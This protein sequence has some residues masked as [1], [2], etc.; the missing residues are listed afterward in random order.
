MRELI[1]FAM[2]ACSTEPPAPSPAQWSTVLD[3]QDR[4]LLSVWGSGNDVFAVGGG[5]GNG[6]PTLAM[7][8]DGSAW[9]ELSPGGADTFWWVNG[10]SP[11]DVWMVGTG[12]RIAHWDGTSF[13]PHTSGTSETLWGVWAFSP[14]DAWAV[15]KVVLHFDGAAW[16]KAPVLVDRNLF[17]VWGTSSSDLYAVGEG[18][19][20]LH[21]AGSTWKTEPSSTTGTLFTVFGCSAKEVY[22]VGG[23]D[24]LRSD[25]TT[26]SRVTVGLSNQVNGVSCNAG[27]VAIVGFGG[28][29][30][31]LVSGRWIDEFDVEPYVDLHAVWADGDGFWAVGGDWLTAAAPGKPRRGVIARFK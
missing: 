22:A 29:K 30:Q 20:I 23:S 11:N 9:N 31:R 17:K 8:Y 16:T 10:T 4:V 27:K 18:G 7:H 26:W 28:L 21:R 24:V 14:N 25:G 19:T 6:Q 5:L 3:K 1:A 15:G 12:G 2:C 13:T